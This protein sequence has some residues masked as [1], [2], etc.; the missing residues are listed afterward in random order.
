MS[1]CC[2]GCVA[3]IELRPVLYMFPSR[4]PLKPFKGAASED[5]TYM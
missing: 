1:R 2:D 3:A 5:G 4:E